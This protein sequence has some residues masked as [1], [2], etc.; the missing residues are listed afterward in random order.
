MGGVPLAAA[1]ACLAALAL[2][3]AA[4][5]AAPCSEPPHP[6]GEWPTYGVDLANS[7]SQPAERVIGAGNAGALTPAF[8]HRAPGLVNTTPI[9]DGGCLFVLSQGAARTVARLAVLDADDGAPVWQRDLEVGTAAF[10]GTAVGTPALTED[11]VLLA[12]NRQGGPFVLAL[13]RATGEERWR[14]EVDDQRNSGINGS[15]VVFDGLVVVGFFGNADASEHERGGF[16]VLDAATGELLRKTFVIGDEDFEAGYAG[17]G[18]WSTPAVDPETGYA[19]AG[20]SNPHSPQREHPRSNSILKLD[21]DRDRETFGDIVASY[22][23]VHDT[24]VPGAADQ[25]ACALAPGVYYAYS[26]SATCLAF[27]LDFGASPNLFRDGAGRLRVG[28]LQKAGVYHV[29]DAADLAPVSRTPVGA[30]CFACNAASSAF[31][32]G[33][34]YVA[35][36]PPGQMV[37]VDGDDG[38][39]SWVAPIGAGFTYNPVTVANGVV[40][41]VDAL[42]S[43]NAF[44]ADTGAPVV[45]R[46]LRDDTGVSMV[47]ATTS[48]G[49]A[50]AR[51]T[52]YVAA[53]TFVL[54][55][56]PAASAG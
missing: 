15:P 26:F 42:G 38:T 40:W 25:P 18:I 7:R 52:L 44:D 43:L 39:P 27:D 32:G 16:V 34:A 45:K 13:D 49:I 6:A 31:S 4:G 3:A 55:Y 29:V 12:L 41:S 10:G 14:T 20:T 30:L 19:Y 17:A 51:N 5:A 46:R 8:V 21:L 53:T 24:L 56:R 36:G 28:E 2:P 54:A 35:A 37:A 11:L 33:R 22:K 1:V 47:E 23:G 9:V 48:S 50:V